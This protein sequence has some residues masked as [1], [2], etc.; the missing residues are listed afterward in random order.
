MTDEILR[1][2]IIPVVKEAGVK[3]SKRLGFGT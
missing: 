2:K 3:V 1:G